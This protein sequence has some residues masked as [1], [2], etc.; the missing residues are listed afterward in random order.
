MVE[1]L[2]IEISQ[3]SLV[4]I[5]SG[6][7]GLL[8]SM[9]GVVQARYKVAQVRTQSDAQLQQV[10]TEAKAELERKASELQEEQ[11]DALLAMQHW[12]TEQIEL[13]AKQTQALMDTNQVLA[14]KLAAEQSRSEE[15][16]N[17]NVQWRE[18]HDL[19]FTHA[20]NQTRIAEKERNLRVRCQEA[21]EE[22]KIRSEHLE[23]LMLAAKEGDGKESVKETDQ[24]TDVGDSG[25]AE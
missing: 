10:K 18:K 8:G 21:N 15:L 19:M 13:A 7:F 17:S 3:E 6:L 12:M 22:L 5:F 1:I 25:L 24:A 20:M 9:V 16:Q 14:Q 11:Q 4:I 23:V 2:G